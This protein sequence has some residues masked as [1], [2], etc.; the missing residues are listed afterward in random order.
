MSQLDAGVL[1]RIILNRENVSL[2]E[3]CIMELNYAV[4]VF[5]VSHIQYFPNI[6]QLT[7]AQVQTDILVVATMT[8]LQQNAVTKHQELMELLNSPD[9]TDTLSY[10]TMVQIYYQQKYVSHFNFTLDFQ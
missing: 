10:Q 1:K 7:I 8:S 2:L 5:G 4:H 3:E 9:N 6:S